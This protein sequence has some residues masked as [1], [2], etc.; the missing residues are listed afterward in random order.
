MEILPI[1]PFKKF[2]RAEITPPGSKSITNRALLLAALRPGTTRI[3]GALFSEDTLTM[4]DCLRRLGFRVDADSVAKTLVVEGLGGEIPAAR[5]ELFVANAG[6]AARFLTAALALKKGGE[7]TL[8]GSPAMRK[9]PMDGLLAALAPLGATFDFHGER[10]RFPFTMHTR[11]IFSDETAADARASSQILSA[12]MLV[13]PVVASKTARGL[14]DIFLKGETVSAPFV[15]MTAKMISQ[16]GGAVEIRG[17]RFTCGGGYRAG[18]LDYAVE[19]DATAASYFLILPFIHRGGEIFVRGLKTDGLQ[20]DAAF[21]TTL[22]TPPHDLLAFTQTDA[23][24]LAATGTATRGFDADFNAISDTFL[25]L[26]AVAPLLDPAGAPLVIR[27]IAHTRGQETDRVA[28]MANELSKFVGAENVSQTQ[29]S[30]TVRPVAREILRARA[31]ASPDG[32]IRVAT[33]RDH[34]VAM[35]FGAL[36]TFDLRGDGSPWLE[37]EDPACC[38]KTFPEFFRVL[39]ALGGN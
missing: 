15:E 25:T 12:L 27:G 21:A 22:A 18:A 31:D 13:A 11:G 29:D 17:N 16:F 3:S 26:A 35:S 8:D 39:G 30:L 24:G 9:R 38:G 1:V 4:V 5:A 28:A 23:G 34:R 33:Y 14:F 6:T 36:G 2:R 10:G 37:I 19:P 20:G 32:K 7:Y